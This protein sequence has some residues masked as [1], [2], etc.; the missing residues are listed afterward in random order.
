MSKQT[1]QK[2]KPTASPTSVKGTVP[3][4]G[5]DI[6][7]GSIKGS[8]GL[9]TSKIIESLQKASKR[10]IFPEPQGTPDE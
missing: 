4:A 9:S 5:K 7:V 3:I 10:D 8:E 2:D 6:E 1:T